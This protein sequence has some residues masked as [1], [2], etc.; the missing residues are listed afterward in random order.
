[1]KLDVL[2]FNGKTNKQ[3]IFKNK[4]INK[5]AMGGYQNNKLLIFIDC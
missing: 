3:N 5:Q 1:M 4:I 2:F